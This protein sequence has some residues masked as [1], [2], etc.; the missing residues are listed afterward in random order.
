MLMPT[1]SDVAMKLSNAAP[2]G[3]SNTLVQDLPGI[4]VAVI[5][6]FCGPI[7]LDGRTGTGRSFTAIAMTRSYDGNGFP[8]LVIDDFDP[9]QPLLITLYGSP[10]V[11][12]AAKVSYDGAGTNVI[13]LPQLLGSAFLTNY[14][15]P[16]VFPIGLQNIQ[17]TA[18]FGMPVTADVWE[19]VRCEVAYRALVQAEV[20]IDGFGEVME[21]DGF[22]Y[23]SSVGASQFQETS[24]LAVMHGLYMAATLRYRDRGTRIWKKRAKRV[25]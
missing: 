4:L 14:A 20:G 5:A 11:S 18:T 13:F 16:G 10:L 1:V 8:E 19:A 3:L 15:L 17:V 12:A 22:K 6:E 25:S 21:I 2:A 24:S 9:T 7:S 23:D